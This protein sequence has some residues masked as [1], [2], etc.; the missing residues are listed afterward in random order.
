[1]VPDKGDILAGH[2]PTIVPIMKEAAVSEDT[3][4]ALHLAITAARAT[5]WPIDAPIITH[6][7]TPTDNLTLTTSATDVTHTNPETG[8]SLTPATPTA[9]HRKHI[10]DKS[11]TFNP[12]KPYHSKTVTIQ[13]SPPDYSSDSDSDSDPLNSLACPAG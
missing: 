10:Q 9:L 1:M 5:L 4:H 7:V 13:D 3:P 11:K 8:A 6:T 2:S 12:H